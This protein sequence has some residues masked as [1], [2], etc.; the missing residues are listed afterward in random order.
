MFKAFSGLWAVVFLPLFFLLFPTP[1]SPIVMFNEY[2]E[3]TRFVET[4]KGTFY[5]LAKRLNAS[6]QALW[7]DEIKVLSKQFGYDLA[8][9]HIDKWPDEKTTLINDEFVFINNEPELLLKKVQ[10]TPWVITMSVD[11]QVAENIYRSSKGTLYLLQQEFNLAQ[12]LQWQQKLDELQERFSLALS[13]LTI[14]Q[15]ELSEPLLK[16]LKNDEIVWA[17]NDSNRLDF[18][19]LLPD[20]N[21]VIKAEE[22]PI[23]S[24][25]PLLILIILVTFIVIISVAMFLWVS[26][27]WRDLS[28][29]NVIATKF[30]DGALD[31]RA[32]ITKQSTV[33]KLAHSFNKMADKIEQL[34]SS[35]KQL[36]RAIAHD[37][38]TPLYRL[39]FAV[40]MVKSD[41]MATAEKEPYFDAIDKS[42]N[43]L[44]QLINQTLL[45]SRYT[46]TV[47][48]TQFSLQ[49]L[50]KIIQHEID[51]FSLEDSKV[52]IEFEVDEKLFNTQINIDKKA[53][54]RALNNLVANAS[55]YA[56]SE[57]L[58]RL[59][60]DAKLDESSN[61]SCYFLS[62]EDDGP[63]IP[64]K[65]WQNIFAPF[66]QIDNEQRDNSIGHGLGLA[67]VKQIIQWH[68]G[69]VTLSK[70]DLGGAKFVLSWP[71]SRDH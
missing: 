9:T 33:A 23:S 27:L 28:K 55:R 14:S 42:I 18:Y 30:G 16:K 21:K 20:K 71:A 60:Q 45:L 39:R 19:F 36:T 7:V 70:S 37:L 3:K 54:V 1:Y 59:Y 46:S 41:E 47:D 26:P 35:Q 38:R 22:I 34:F 52:D 69:E 6:E 10:N 11:S 49:P 48:I 66:A 12:E 4:Y 15:L 64:E 8:L 68:N 31:E 62:V 29:L 61:K 44:D 51:Y 5:L 65:E 2:A 63:G 25:S 32:S 13:I 17:E 58:I 53:M 50:A 56:D 67:I 43:D 40:E 57:I 24:V